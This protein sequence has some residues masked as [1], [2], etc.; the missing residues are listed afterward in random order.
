MQTNKYER[1]YACVNRAEETCDA[2]PMEKIINLISEDDLSVAEIRAKIFPNLTKEDEDFLSITRRITSFLMHLREQ[3]GFN[4]EIRTVQSETPITIT[5]EV[6]WRVDEHGNS[7]FI[8]AY[9]KDGNFLDVICN[10]KFH[11]TVR[12]RGKMVE[13]KKN[14][15]PTTT[16]YRLRGMDY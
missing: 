8:E 9:D 15:Y 4:L 16:Y 11:Y 3:R 13:T 10:P 7:E 2:I 1:M 14:I 5:K 6:Y 12:V